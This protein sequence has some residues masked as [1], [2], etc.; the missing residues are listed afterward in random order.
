MNSSKL[1][2]PESVEESKVEHITAMLSSDPVPSAMEGSKGLAMEKEISRSTPQGRTA[3]SKASKFATFVKRRESDVKSFAIESPFAPNA[4]LGTKS[5]AVKKQ[6]S[7]QDIER[8][9]GDEAKVM[10]VRASGE[11]SRSDVATSIPK[12]ASEPKDLPEIRSPLSFKQIASYPYSIRL[13]AF[14]TLK[15]AKKAVSIYN[16]KGFSPYWVEVELNNETWHRVYVGH[17]KSHKKAERF[18]TENRLMEAVVKKKK[19]TT[20]ININTAQES[21]GG[22]IQYLKQLGYCPYAIEYNDGQSRLFVGAFVTKDGAKKQCEDLE[23]IG[24]QG[25]LVER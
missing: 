15:G 20:L 14:R 21:L 10:K 24:I 17:F 25:Q 18:R 13:G 5:R 6:L 22:R 9:S 7:R 19:Y 11:R 8:K 23:S 1:K 16:K 2:R 4:Q 3:V 12:P